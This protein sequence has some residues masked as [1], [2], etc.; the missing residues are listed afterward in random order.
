MTKIHW[1]FRSPELLALKLDSEPCHF[2]S[3]P[4]RVERDECGYYCNGYVCCDDC[5]EEINPEPR[6]NFIDR[7]VLGL[8]GPRGHLR[9]INTG[10]Y[11]PYS[12]EAL[13]CSIGKLNFYVTDVYAWNVRISW[14]G[15]QLY[16][17]GAYDRRESLVVRFFARIMAAFEADRQVRWHGIPDW[18][19]D[20]EQCAG[21]DPNP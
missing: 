19:H 10:G 6:L 20:A 14:G 13:D 12:G 8:L 1:I 18:V 3:K 21:W 7:V 11:D 2:C 17:K 16:F 9:H 5:A 15:R 4:T